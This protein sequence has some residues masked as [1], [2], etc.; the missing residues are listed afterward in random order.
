MKTCNCTLTQS[1]FGD[2]CPI[3]QPETWAMMNEMWDEDCRQIEREDIAYAFNGKKFAIWDE[4][5]PG[6]WDVL[7]EYF[8]IK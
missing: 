7:A 6:A 1:M 3:C 8:T 4:D 5:E 2:G